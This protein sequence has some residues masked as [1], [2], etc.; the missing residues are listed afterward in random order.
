V[1][2]NAECTVLIKTL[3]KTLFCIVV[4]MAP[5]PNILHRGPVLRCSL[6]AATV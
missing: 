1:V 4:D 6:S 5:I 3:A 2:I